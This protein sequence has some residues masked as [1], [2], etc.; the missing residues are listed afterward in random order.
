MCSSDLT[1]TVGDARELLG[2]TRKY[3]VP[4][5]EWFDA[6]GVTRRRGDSRIAGPLIDAPLTRA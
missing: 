1:V 3:V 6:N 4:L 2:S 5:L